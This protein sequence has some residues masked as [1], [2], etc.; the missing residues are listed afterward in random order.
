FSGIFSVGIWRDKDDLVHQDLVDLSTKM[1]G[2]VL[3]SKADATV[4][5]YR[6]AFTCWKKWASRFKEITVLPANSFHV[7][8]YL[9]SLIQSGKRSPVIMNAVYGIRWA[10]RVAG[11]PDPCQHDL[12]KNITEAARR[13]YSDPLKKKEPIDVVILEKL[14]VRFGREDCSLLDLRFL[15]MSILS[16]A[17]FF[18]FSEVS[19]IR[20]SDISFHEGYVRIFIEKSKTDVYRDGRFIVVAASGS[21]LCPVR[22]LHR[23]ISL[24]NI[25]EDS[26]EFIFRQVSYCKKQRIYVLRGN[27]PISYTR[28]REIFR[29]KCHEIGIDVN[30]FGLH[31]FRAGGAT[32]AA[33]AGVPDRLFKRH[34]RWV[35]DTAKDGYVKDDIKELLSVTSMLGL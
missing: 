2:I 1:P 4:V 10:H 12:I 27:K 13:C 32:A 14:V 25:K 28:T 21:K 26:H 7:G 3:K 8:L 30:S 29:E 11:L 31:S 22:M 23:Y 5:K 34:G 19:S 33:N 15:T 6:R 35:S 16:Y 24:A 20:R 17:G 9:M 18:R